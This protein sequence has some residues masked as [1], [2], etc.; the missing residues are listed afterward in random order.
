[1]EFGLHISRGQFIIISKAS[2]SIARLMML[3][4]DR[5]MLKNNVPAAASEIHER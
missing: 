1:M 5:Q 3:H 4:M 2:S